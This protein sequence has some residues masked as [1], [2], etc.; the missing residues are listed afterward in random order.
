[1]LLLQLA[2]LF[3]PGTNY[4]FSGVAG[5][6]PGLVDALGQKLQSSAA[7]FASSSL[8]AFAAAPKAFAAAGGFSGA[9]APPF[10]AL[11]RGALPDSSPSPP[12][13]YP[14]P[15]TA[16]TLRGQPLHMTG[17]SR[18]AEISDLLMLQHLNCSNVS[19]AGRLFTRAAQR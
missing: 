8:G 18:E 14:L 9:G 5:S 15:C 13:H 4:S 19:A 17:T 11:S 1:M 7:T 16:S 3:A 2:A 12:P 6:E 10:T